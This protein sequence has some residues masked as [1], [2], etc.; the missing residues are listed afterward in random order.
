MDNLMTEKAM[1]DRLKQD[2]KSDL[3]GKLIMAY[4]TIR[5]MRDKE[6][7][8]IAQRGRALEALEKAARDFVSANGTRPEWWT[9][10][11]ELYQDKSAL[12]SAESK[13]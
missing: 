1:K 3:I 2:S 5:H 7:D 12:A 8:L 9:N 11:L 13:P 10:V 6:S 4:M